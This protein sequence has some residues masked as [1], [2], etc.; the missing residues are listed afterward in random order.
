MKDINKFGLLHYSI[1][2]QLDA[3]QSNNNDFSIYFNFAAGTVVEV[4]VRLPQLD[5]YN[6]LVSQ[7]HDL[8]HTSAAPDG[9][10]NLAWRNKKYIAFDEV[11][12]TSINWSIQ[13]RY[14]NPVP[15]PAN[16]SQNMLSR[17]SC[18][19][20][21]DRGIGC[22]ALTFGYRGANTVA[23]GA[24]PQQQS[25]NAGARPNSGS[26]GQTAAVGNIQANGNGRYSFRDV[27][28]VAHVNDDPLNGNAAQFNQVQ[29]AGVTIEKMSM[30]VQ[31][32]LGAP[33]EAV[34]SQPL[35][36]NVVV[37]RGRVR[38]I[39]YV[40][41][42]AGAGAVGMFAFRMSIPPCL[43]PPAMLYLQLTVP[44]TRTKILGQ[45]DER[46]GWAVPTPPNNFLSKFD[47]LPKQALYSEYQ[48]RSMPYIELAPAGQKLIRWGAA[49]ANQGAVNLA[50]GIGYNFDCIPDGADNQVGGI[51]W[52]DNFD[53]TNAAS[54]SKMIMFGITRAQP[55]ASIR[56]P[57]AP[58]YKYPK[59]DRLQAEGGRPSVGFGMGVFR[60]SGVF[61][62][63]MIEPNWVFTDTEDS[64]IQTFDIQLLWGD[65]SQAVSAVAANPVQFSIIAAP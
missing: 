21:F 58:A 52:I 65:T 6:C 55:A 31:L 10:G 63:S 12:Q 40:C 62:A 45:E 29:L 35:G 16:I 34:S 14:A 24:D 54:A 22:Y 25:M 2:K 50:D 32:M 13:H 28:G 7:A 19:V 41:T 1:P 11:L 5:Y 61:T 57:K 51:R 30:R 46:G 20:E 33:A 47:N 8:S 18:V 39:N 42:L 3:L 23:N 9:G 15:A 59:M 37:T 56:D 60:R 48:C 49:Y 64:T 4:P 36:N 26:P 27:N 44:G 53:C 38:L 43:D 17:I